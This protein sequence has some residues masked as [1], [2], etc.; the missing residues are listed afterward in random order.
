MKD[1][2]SIYAAGV[3]TRML[4]IA[5]LLIA[6]IAAVD[7]WVPHYISLGFLYL[8]PIIIVGGFLSRTWIVAVALLCAVLQ[9]AFSNL[10]ENEAVIRLLFSSAGF[11]G[12]GL[13]ISEMVRNRRIV[14]KH[15]EELEDQVK[16][17]QDAEQQLRSLVESSPAAIITIDSDGKVLLA[18]EAAQQLL[19]PGRAPLQGQAVRAYLPALRTVLKTQPSRAFRTTLQCTGRRSDGEVFLAGVWFSTYSTISGPRLAAIIVD[20]SEDLRSREELSLDHLLKNSRILMSTVAH[21]IRNL[22]GAVLVVHKNLSRIKQLETNEDFRALG[23][24]IQSLER[25]SALELGS[26]PAQNGEAVELTSVLDE[27]RILIETT[28]HESA[29]DV[30]WEI[31]EALPLVWADRYGLVQVF[32]NLAKNSQRAMAATDTKRLRIAAHEQD[33]KV[34]IRFEDTGTGVASP[35]DLFQPFQRGAKSSGLGLFVS[36]A[37]MRSFGGELIHEPRSDG[38]CFTVLLPLHI[39]AEE[40]VS[41]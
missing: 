12:T 14:L 8:F 22:S 24:L 26:T 31:Q 32:L 29:I 18:N 13:F 30:Q 38:A 20:L 28:Y 5:C 10:P 16:L 4:V 23:G 25:M 3:R 15:S 7:W 27:L 11:V 6:A 33:G 36:R 41:A 21:E 1:L 34:V 9:E 39:A 2:L 19:S 37:I 40:P 17:R 35:E